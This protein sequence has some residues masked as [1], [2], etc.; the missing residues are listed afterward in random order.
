MH[1]ERYDHARL[2]S[3]NGIANVARSAPDQQIVVTVTAIIPAH[4]A[5]GYLRQAVDSALGQRGVDVEVIVIDDGSTDETW[6]IMKG[7]GDA[8]RAIQVVQGGPYKARNHGARLAVGRWLAFLDADDE[9]L[10]DK[11]AKQLALTEDGTELVYTDCLN[12][13][14]TT[15]YK[16]RLSDSQRLCEG[17]AFEPLLRVNFITLSSVLISKAAFERLDGF[18]EDLSGV[19]DWD[20]WL[21]YAAQGGRI[22]VCVEPLTRYRL[23]AG[24]ISSNVEERC[25][26]RLEVLR[27]VLDLPRGRQV[28]GSVASRARASAWEISASFAAHTRP[29]LAIAWYL[30]SIGYWPW[31]MQPYKEILKCCIGVVNGSLDAPHSRRSRYFDS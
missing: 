17:D 26:D 3:G 25:R 31:K 29:G 28:S 13:G 30:R 18:C 6:A 15:H 24:S 14:G 23:H 4:N 2:E 22:R 16:E 11:L 12:F 5:A 27:R 19:M 8:I 20:L 9:W 21:R 7:Y 1:R 10:P